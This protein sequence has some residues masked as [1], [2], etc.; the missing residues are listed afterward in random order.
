MHCLETA[1]ILAAIG[2]SKVVIAAGLLHDTI[3]ESS[4]KF[5]QLESQF[6]S[7][8]ATLVNGVL[9]LFIVSFECLISCYHMYMFNIEGSK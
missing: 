8:V 4:I 2:A 1:K 5:T 6:G 7:E 3:D 9:M